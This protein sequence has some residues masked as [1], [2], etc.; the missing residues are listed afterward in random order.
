MGWRWAG[1]ATE[2]RKSELLDAVIG[3]LGAFALLS[4]PGVQA[5]CDPKGQWV[6][7]LC[8]YGMVTKGGGRVP[9]GWMVEER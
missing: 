4:R 1:P 6:S 2:R 8:P 5:N 7:I 9:N 3:L